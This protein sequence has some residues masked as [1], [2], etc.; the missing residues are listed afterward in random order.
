MK[1]IVLFSDGTGNSSAK[2]L[3]T[4]VWRLY[5]A[6]DLGEPTPE[7]VARGEVRQIAYYDDGVGTSSFKPVAILGGALGY[8]LKRNVLDLYTFLC[9]NY[10][11]GDR[12]YAFGFSRGAFTIRV[13]IG[14]VV[15]RGLL[16][17]RTEQE[18]AYQARDAYRTYRRRFQ[19]TG[20]PIEALR[21]LRDGFIDRWRKRHAQVSY[22]EL[23]RTEVDKIALV[24]VWDTVAAYGMPIAELT[25]AIDKWIWPLSMPDLELSP[26]VERARHALALDDER[27][28]FHPLLWDEVAE[29]RRVEEAAQDAVL[30]RTCQLAE[31]QADFTR[32]DQPTDDR[33]DRLQQVWFAGM[34]ADVGG[35]YPDDSLA[36]VSLEWM[37]REATDAGL[38]FTRFA[39]DEVKRSRNEYGPMHDSRR[40][41]G[42]Y[43]RYQPRKLAARLDPPDPTALIMQ[44]P[45]LKGRGL[46]TSMKIHGSVIDRIHAGTDDYAPI[47]LPAD[48]QIVASGKSVTGLAE[49]DPQG[50]AR[51]QNGLVGNDVW[52]RRVNY[53][54]TV[55]AS[56]YLASM[57]WLY[58]L[59][60]ACLGPQC[61]LAPVISGLGAVL[62]GFVQWWIDSWAQR[63]GLFLAGATVLTLLLFRGAYLQRST[64]DDMRKVWVQSLVARQ[65][66]E[67]PRPKRR[68]DDRILAIRT[69]P[70]YQKVLQTLKWQGIPDMFGGAIHTTGALLIL[71]LLLVPG[72]RLYIAL[73]DGWGYRCVVWPT[74][75]VEGA[76][77]VEWPRFDT[78]S[79][80]WPTGLR[81][82]AGKR[83]RIT[84][85]VP[86]DALWS[87]RE[88]PADPAGIDSGK[89]PWLVQ[90]GAVFLRRSL[91]DRWLQPLAKIVPKGGAGWFDWAVT[92]ALDMR[93]ADYGDRVYVADL[94]AEKAGDLYLF[95]NDALLPWPGP[96]TYFYDNNS[97][98]AEVRVE[99]ID[100]PA[101]ASPASR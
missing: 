43:Y 75:R 82:E 53:F 34:H 66:V 45:D 94:E 21:D 32:P 25:R 8:G 26:K 87:D 54:M 92:K 48:Y 58:E 30:D 60:R 42:G 95:V 17:G 89:M 71:A 14:L 2:V 44:D 80:C 84:L 62:P 77:K 49:F 73:A 64:R 101:A 96:L 69:H 15:T 76:V 72:F 63:P 18:L 13:L 9:R 11:P 52:Q 6:L 50:R 46:L 81:L 78:S 39:W 16:L 41:L 70:A 10:E 97:G 7:Q 65:P 99:R 5:Q 3:K 1:A 22:P 85:T 93:R 59:D 35:G 19:Q 40:G 67:P 23:A 27:D 74:R 57:P 12:I 83:Y 91:D 24:G 4:N 56:L 68:F 55:G 47:V 20:K 36:Y 38:R 98:E 100:P 29:H 61:L 51:E 31:A 86:E 88:I 79:M 90:H 28:T 37:M 33:P